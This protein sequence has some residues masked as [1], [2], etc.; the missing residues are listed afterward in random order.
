MVSANNTST[1]TPLTVKLLAESTIR[2]RE[3]REA[4]TVRQQS[5]DNELAADS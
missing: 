5:G 1:A 4:Q 2:Y 3:T